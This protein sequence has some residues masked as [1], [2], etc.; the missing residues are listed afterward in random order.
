[1]PFSDVRLMTSTMIIMIRVITEQRKCHSFKYDRHA[2]INGLEC[3]L[4]SLSH[5]NG[6]NCKKLQLPDIQ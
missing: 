2:S 1:M 4:K 3:R 5:K 6:L